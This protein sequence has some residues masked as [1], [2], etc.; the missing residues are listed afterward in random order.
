MLKNSSELFKLYKI[1]HAE[2][3]EQ[4]KQIEQTEQSEQSELTVIIVI[5]ENLKKGLTSASKNV[6]KC[7]CIKDPNGVEH[8]LEN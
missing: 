2:H 4:T 5:A 7:E 3:I 1:F 8:Y 6:I